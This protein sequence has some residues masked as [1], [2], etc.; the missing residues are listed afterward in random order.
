MNVFQNHE[1]SYPCF[2]VQVDLYK[3]DANKTE[4]CLPR[5]SKTSNMASYPR[6]LWN[7]DDEVG[8]LSVVSHR[9]LESSSTNVQDESLSG[10]V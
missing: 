4:F 5:V 8:S 1:C 10:H 9:R 3:M 2:G 6:M 7:L